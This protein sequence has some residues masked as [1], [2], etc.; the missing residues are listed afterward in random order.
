ML[1]RTIIS[2]RKTCRLSPAIKKPKQHEPLEKK[3]KLETVLKGSRNLG[4]FKLPFPQAPLLQWQTKSKIPLLISCSC[5]EFE[6]RM[7]A[8]VQK[9]FKIQ[10]KVAKDD[11]FSS[12]KV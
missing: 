2:T 3:R 7:N 9:T 8:D 1:F 11:L 5:F 12:F 10:G 6:W 4:T